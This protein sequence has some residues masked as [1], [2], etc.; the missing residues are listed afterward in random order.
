[1]VHKKWSGC[2]ASTVYS[3]AL[4]G[5]DGQLVEPIKCCECILT[6]RGLY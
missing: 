1:M 5:I 3:F 2:M 4:K 6:S